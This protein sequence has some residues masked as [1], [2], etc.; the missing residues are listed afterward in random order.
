MAFKHRTLHELAAHVEHYAATELK[1][2]RLTASLRVCAIILYGS[3]AKYHLGMVPEYRD[4]DLN[5]FLRKTARYRTGDARHLNRRGRCWSAS[6]FMGKGVDVMFN[7]VGAS[8]DWRNSV[9]K[10]ASSR[11]CRIKAAPIVEVHP[12]IVVYRRYGAPA[13]RGMGPRRVLGG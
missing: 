8:Q 10:R 9:A 11:W 3:A 4:F 2:K 6:H 13:A 5:V 1:R 12:E 7:V